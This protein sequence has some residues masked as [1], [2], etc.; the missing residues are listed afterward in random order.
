[1]SDEKPRLTRDEQ[2]KR[3][4]EKAR[5]LDQQAAQNAVGEDAKLDAMV[6]KSIRDHGS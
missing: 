5:D 3:L 6:R 2:R 4:R 1:M